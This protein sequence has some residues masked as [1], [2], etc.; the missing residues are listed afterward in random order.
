MACYMYYNRKF[1]LFVIKLTVSNFLYFETF[2][3]QYSKV[4]VNVLIKIGH[5]FLLIV[6][7]YFLIVWIYKL[8]IV[9][10]TKCNS[11]FCTALSLTAD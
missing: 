5:F 9:F 8:D 11:Y 2:V 6:F 7:V 10:L 3:D 1:E 4:Y